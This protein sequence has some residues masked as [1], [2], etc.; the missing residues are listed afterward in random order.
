MLAE[1]ERKERIKKIV[2]IIDKEGNEKIGEVW[3]N[4]IQL[5]P[6]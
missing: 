6:S 4:E 5:F 2:H 3:Q 1:R